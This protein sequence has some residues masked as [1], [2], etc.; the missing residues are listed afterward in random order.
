MKILNFGALNIDYVYAVEEIVRGGQTISASELSRSMGGKGLNQSVA[1][2]RAGARVY[3]AGCV[4]VDGGFL[5]D[6]LKENGV[7]TGFIRC[8]EAPT[9]HAMIQVDRQGQNCI[10]IYGGANKAITRAHID[11]VM[12]HFDPEDAILLQNEIND[13]RYIAQKAR[14]KGMTVILNPSPVTGL[15]VPLDCVDLF[16]LNE[17]EAEEIFGGKTVEELTVKMR[18]ACPKARFVLTLGEQGA[19]Y[20]DRE[21][22]VAVPAMKIKAVDTTAAGDTFTGFFLN[23]YFSG[24]G[25]GEAL[26]TAAKAAAIAVSRPG[27]SPSIPHRSE[28]I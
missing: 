9:G 27:A 19:V 1:L 26:K 15:D 6:F 5:V 4:G 13:V 14:E 25:I 22:T 24:A 18:L 3:H 20:V 10:I 16:L 8:V 2:A 12:S 17:L 7:D 23:A 28:L 21:Q 11:E